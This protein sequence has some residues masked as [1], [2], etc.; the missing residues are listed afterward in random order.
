MV[1]ARR[2][3]GGVIGGFTRD[4]EEKR[5]EWDR[6]FKLLLTTAVELRLVAVSDLDRDEVIH[7]QR[8]YRGKG[9]TELQ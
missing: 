6:L 7:C 1:N 2:P 3:E 8:G 5:P 9:R 4:G